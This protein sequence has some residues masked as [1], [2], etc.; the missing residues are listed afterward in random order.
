MLFLRVLRSRLSRIGNIEGVKII[1]W[2][3]RER[4]V[5]ISFHKTGLLPG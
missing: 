5:I 1:R 3:F 4:Q 2:C